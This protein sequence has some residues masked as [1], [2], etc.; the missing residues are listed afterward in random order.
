LIKEFPDEEPFWLALYKPFQ[1]VDLINRDLRELYL[2]EIYKAALFFELLESDKDT[3]KILNLFLSKYSCE[4]WVEYL[5]AST[6]LPANTL[7]STEGKGNNF[8]EIDPA[9]TFYDVC[10]R[11]LDAIS[12]PLEDIAL[13]DDHLF[14]RNH[15]II[16]T[17]ENKFQVVYKR[18]LIEKIFRALYFEMS[19]I[20]HDSKIMHRDKFRS[21]IYTS[22]YSEQ[23][24]L[25]SAL[26]QVFYRAVQKIHG[27]V[28]E[29][30]DPAFG[31]SDYVAYQNGS[32]FLFESKD[33]LIRKEVKQKLYIPELRTELFKKFYKDE[34][35]DKAVLQLARNIKNLLDGKY[36]KFGLVFQK[37]R[38]IYP[39]I[40]VH[41]DAF[42]VLGLNQL[43]KKWFRQA[44]DEVGISKKE[45]YKIKSVV[46]IDCNTLL[47]FQDRIGAK[48]TSLE[49]LID[50][51]LEQTKI[52][53]NE[54][55]QP[56]SV[57]EYASRYL[58]PFSQ[59]VENTIK[60]IKPV[61]APQA[62][63]VKIKEILLSKNA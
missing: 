61:K 25:Y 37:F 8:V 23:N 49:Q 43:L 12:I 22:G 47:Y 54:K 33:I 26:D 38:T 63:R 11:I 18:F 48:G 44:C 3:V 42:T 17:A 36:E 40:V 15:P 41:S 9:L 19:R 6:G 32:I 51:Y 5:I 58:V 39:V 28:M 24:I 60:T 57:V 59:Y 62:M 52:G 1:Y 55:H 10:I 50:A 13:Q 34:D 46:L 31:A 21:M 56:R 20:G 35:G 2:I 45:S 30:A 7:D 14:L 53:T 4:T 29:K 27:N 16:R